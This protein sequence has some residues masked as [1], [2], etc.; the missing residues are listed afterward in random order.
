MPAFAIALL[1]AALAA[2]TFAFSAGSGGSHRAVAP[3]APATRADYLRLAEAGVAASRDWWAPRRHWYRQTLD[4][5]S[6]LATNW[7]IVHLFGAVDA[8]AIADPT[9]AHRAAVR[10]FAAG[11]ERYWNPD[12]RPVPGY[13]PYPGNHGAGHRSWYDDEGWWG[14]AFYDA[15]RATGDR[16]YL[17][18]AS[19][20]LAFLDS[21][22]DPRSGGIYWD[23][24]RTF[25]S[26]ESLTGATLLAAY[27]YDATHAP[28]YLSLVRKYVTW[29]DASFRG[30]DGLYDRT[31][32]DTTPLPYVEGPM[33]VAF[34]VLCRSTGDRAWCTKAESLADR[35]VKRFPQ[36][37]MGPQY[38]SMYVRSLLE[39]Y[40]FDGNR[41]WYDVAAAATN[42]A[43]ANARAPN[44]LYLRAWDGR[45]IGTIG[46][47]PLKLQTHAATTSV[48]AWMAASRP[49]RGP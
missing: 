13:G 38:D 33:A 14:I 26:G 17:A 15:Y 5:T 36:L 3:S 35:A 11:A 31:E 10:T 47:P 12:L 21:G 48:A 42:R 7:G 18:S 20:A 25:K 8:L 39:L 6:P 9:P 22:W 29:A 16:R 23:T 43:V 49:P 40:R 32:H 45:P 4:R 24:R 28:R 30:S 34:A 41:R 2:A 37:T 1:V 19:R 44:G 46:T 27:L